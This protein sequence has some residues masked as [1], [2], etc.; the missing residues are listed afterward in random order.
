MKINPY[1]STN[2]VNGFYPAESKNQSVMMRIVNAR[3]QKLKVEA[4]KSPEFKELKKVN[5]SS[6]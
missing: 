6:R 4:L 3:A 5:T 2:K 1:S